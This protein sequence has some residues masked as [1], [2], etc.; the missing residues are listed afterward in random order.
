[1]DKSK[2][3]GGERLLL[4]NAHRNF[5]SKGTGSSHVLPCETLFLS[6]EN[7]KP[8][9]VDRLPASEPVNGRCEGLHHEPKR[10]HRD[11]PLRAT[12]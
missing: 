8:L 2:V 4:K 9:V 12:C 10:R 5:T 6:F 3:E 1:M 7:L 11:G